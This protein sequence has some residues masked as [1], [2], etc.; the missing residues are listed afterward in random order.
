MNEVVGDCQEWSG[1]RNKAGYG[2]VHLVGKGPV[3]AHR[4]AWAL[5]N[6]E[7]PA[8]LV[9][10]HNCHNPPC[11]NPEHL[12]SGTLQDNSDDMVR[13][14]RQ[15][16]KLTASDVLAIRMRR[17]TGEKCVAL[18]KEYGVTHSII[19]RIHTRGIWKH[20]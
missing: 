7:D 3:L 15:A 17:D 2:V 14:G 9:V 5:H 18:A 13:A 16:A 4:L 20:V 1:Y 6:G 8:G 11:V 12:A 19:S 10:R